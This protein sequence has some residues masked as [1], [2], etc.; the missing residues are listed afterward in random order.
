MGKSSRAIVIMVVV[1]LAMVMTA[2]TVPA[3]EYTVTCSVDYTGPYAVI[4]P[5]FES[6]RE[7]FFAWWN[8]T[9][10]KELEEMTG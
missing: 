1:A 4:M 2:Q 8:E 6:S 10:G 7:A 3:V 9:K 5:P